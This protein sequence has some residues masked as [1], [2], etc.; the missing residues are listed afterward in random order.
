M[1]TLF[2]PTSKEFKKRQNTAETVKQQEKV[3]KVMKG[4]RND[5]KKLINEQRAKLEEFA[6]GEGD[7]AELNQEELLSRVHK[8]LGQGAYAIL[9]TALGEFEL[10]APDKA[11]IL[12]LEYII[13]NHKAL[14][15][16]MIENG[17]DYKQVQRAIMVIKNC[18]AAM[19]GF[20]EKA[21]EVAEL[22]VEGDIK[23]QEKAQAL[24]CGSIALATTSVASV[25]GTIAGGIVFPALAVASGG[26]FPLGLFLGGL[27]LGPILATS[28]GFAAALVLKTSELV[29]R[30]FDAVG[31]VSKL[32]EDQANYY[33]KDAEKLEK[34]REQAGEISKKLE[35]VPQALKAALERTGDVSR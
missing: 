34:V 3:A 16:V 13:N 25:A 2:M 18:F 17:A 30:R 32:I 27:I 35:G 33:A 22:L 29:G 6:K 9:N 31:E 5:V 21:E 23:R 26:M 11:M 19:N 10:K 28:F 20:S 12:N 7:Y 4:I 15:E 24:L 1:K 14:Q 8:E